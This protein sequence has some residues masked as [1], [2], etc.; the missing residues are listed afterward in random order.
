MWLFRRRAKADKQTPAA[1]EPS[2]PEVVRRVEITV[3]REWTS[4][5][6]RRKGPADTAGAAALEGERGHK[7]EQG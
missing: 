3:E 6:L 7:G 2:R 1:D 5:V 4:T